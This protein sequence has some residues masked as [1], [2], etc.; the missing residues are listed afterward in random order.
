MNLEYFGVASIH[1]GLVLIECAL[2]FS[3]LWQLLWE[4]M[5]L[6][7]LLHVAHSERSFRVTV[8]CVRFVWSLVELV[9]LSTSNPKLFDFVILE[10]V[11]KDYA[12]LNLASLVTRVLF[13]IEKN[14]VEYFLGVKF[15]M[16]P[17][18]RLPCK[19]LGRLCLLVKTVKYN[20]WITAGTQV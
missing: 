15:I 16:R 5:K 9:V 8:V 10:A 20:I 7:T 1:N 6:W 4:S 13:T 2:E 12:N 17:S 3:L 18:F 19:S 11:S 14:V